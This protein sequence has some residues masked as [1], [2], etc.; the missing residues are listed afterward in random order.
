MERVNQTLKTYLRTFIN[1]DQDDW[2]SLL[3]LAEFA[4][5]NSVTQATQL[6]PSYTNYGYHLKA[7]WTSSEESQNPTSKAYAHWIKATHDRVMQALKKTKDNMSKYYDQHHQLQPGYQ[8][9]D[10]VLL[11][12]KN[13]RTVRPT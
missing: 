1:Y 4:Y 6:I 11:N 8:E 9:G 13:I 12:A 3:P 5:N 2:Y 10:E 7:I